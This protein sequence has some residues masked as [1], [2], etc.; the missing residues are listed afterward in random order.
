MTDERLDEISQVV[1][2]IINANRI[3][4]STPGCPPEFREQWEE[5]SHA[6]RELLEEF[7]QL[8]NRPS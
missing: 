3:T 7:K 5:E 4:A 1:E 8:R 2:D 6:L